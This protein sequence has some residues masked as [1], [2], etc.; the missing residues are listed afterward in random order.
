MYKNEDH[1]NQFGRMYNRDDRSGKYGE[2]SY[3]NQSLDEDDTSKV[4]FKSINFDRNK[5]PEYEDVLPPIAMPMQFDQRNIKF[6]CNRLNAIK[7]TGRKLIFVSGTWRFVSSVLKCGQL[8]DMFAGDY[9]WILLDIDIPKKLSTKYGFIPVRRAATGSNNWVFRRRRERRQ[10]SADQSDEKTSNYKSDNLHHG[11][12]PSGIINLKLK[13]LHRRIESD[14]ST[15]FKNG[16]AAFTEYVFFEGL[17]DRNMKS[18][19]RDWIRKYLYEKDKSKSDVEVNI[20]E[21]TTE[22]AFETSTFTTTTED[23]SST[24][25]STDSYF[26]TQ[27]Y[28]E[29]EKSREDVDENFLSRIHKKIPEKYQHEN[30]SSWEEM[31]SGTELDF[32]PYEDYS[33]NY[34]DVIYD[35]VPEEKNETRV[36][37]I[38]YDHNIPNVEPDFVDETKDFFDEFNKLKDLDHIFGSQLTD[39]VSP[40]SNVPQSTTPTPLNNSTQ[41]TS[42]FTDPETLPI[43]LPNFGEDIFNSQRKPSNNHRN[44]KHSE[45]KHKRHRPLMLMDSGVPRISD[46]R[47]YDEEPSRMPKS[48]RLHQRHLSYLS[49]RRPREAS[50][51][52]SMPTLTPPSHQAS[53]EVPTFS[54]AQ[55]NTDE[56]RKSLGA[57]KTLLLLR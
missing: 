2:N 11:T 16:L 47:T 12:I 26:T 52:S 50:F 7:I 27:N 36:F 5:I 40:N 31:N 37:N 23:S 33:S 39:E 17:L 1:S 43:K 30:I 25:P 53:C 19:G 21:S 42:N 13:S 38:E 45:Q 35:G 22:I 32:G 56:T 54:S 4:P 20:T 29:K 9:V 44:P 48:L 41:I 3:P 28:V 15:F 8:H 51:L 24:D 18:L 14:M 34:D 49:R 6:D 57:E 46:Q 10:N 55:Q